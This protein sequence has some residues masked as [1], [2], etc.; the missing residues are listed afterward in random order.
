M[1]LTRNIIPV[2]KMSGAMKEHI[3]G[4]AVCHCNFKTKK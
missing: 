1:E 3:T 4:K 2:I